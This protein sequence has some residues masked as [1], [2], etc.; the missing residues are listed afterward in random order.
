MGPQRLASFI[1]AG[2]C[3]AV[4]HFGRHFP[5]P[6]RVRHM[7]KRDLKHFINPLDRLDIQIL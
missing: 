3:L 2:G 7:L 4:D 5:I 6:S 1:V